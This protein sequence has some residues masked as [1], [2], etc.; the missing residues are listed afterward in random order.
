MSTILTLCFFVFNTL[1]GLY[2]NFPNYRAFDLVDIGEEFAV[3]D[4]DELHFG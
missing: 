2:A 4:K 3:R 1:P